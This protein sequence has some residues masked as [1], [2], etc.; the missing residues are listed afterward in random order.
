ML[1]RLL[2]FVL[3]VCLLRRGPEDAPAHPYAAA[4]AVVINFALLTWTFA[5][6]G[7]EIPVLPAAQVTLVPLLVIW[8]FLNASGRPER[9]PQTIFTV[10]GVSFFMNL[11]AT[12][13]L[14]INDPDAPLGLLAALIYLSVFVWSFVVDAHILRRALSSSFAL[15]MLLAVLL[16]ITNDMLLS[17]WY[18]PVVE[19]TTP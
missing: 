10:Y 18:T 4:S 12:A 6:N 7:A 8:M 2:A 17:W 1:S 9:F 13:L 19:N 5:R 3:D 14:L 15:G 11:V 16:Y